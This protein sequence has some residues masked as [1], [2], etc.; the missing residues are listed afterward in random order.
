MTLP[1]VTRIVR[2]PSAWS[3]T[4]EK[5]KICKPQTSRS[6][7]AEAFALEAAR[8]AAA[9]AVAAQA[10]AEAEAR[11]TALAATAQAEDG[12]AVR[13]AA[14]E[15]EAAG[16]AAWA[17]REEP[18]NLF[19]KRVAAWANAFDPKYRTLAWVLGMHV[20][21]GT[22]MAWPSIETLMAD[23]EKALIKQ[24]G[25]GGVFKPSRWMVTDRLKGL[26][27]AGVTRTGKQGKKK[28]ETKG[29][30]AT[31][32]Y[33]AHRRFVDLHTVIQGGVAVHRDFY[34]PLASTDD[35]PGPE[36]T[37]PPAAPDPENPAPET[38][39]HR[40][41]RGLSG[42]RNVG[43]VAVQGPDSSPETEWSNYEH[44]TGG[45]T[46]H[47]EGRSNY[48]HGTSDGTSGGT[49]HIT[50]PSNSPTNG[51]KN[52]D[53][54]TPVITPADAGVGEH[55]G[56]QG[57]QGQD[58]DR[59]SEMD[60]RKA[61]W[62]ATGLIAKDFA[63][64]LDHRWRTLGA[65]PVDV[66]RLHQT[67][68]KWSYNHNCGLITLSEA[69]NHWLQARYNDKSIHNPAGLM[70]SEFG[71]WLVWAR[72]APP[73]RLRTFFKVVRDDK[74]IRG[75]KT[76]HALSAYLTYWDER[77]AIRPS[78]RWTA[79]KLVK[80]YAAEHDLE[81]P[82][83]VDPLDAALRKDWD[84][85]RGPD[86]DYARPLDN[87]KESWGVRNRDGT[88]HKID[89]PKEWNAVVTEVFE[90]RERLSELSEYLNS[91]ALDYDHAWADNPAEP[92][93]WDDIDPAERYSEE[94]TG[95]SE[96]GLLRRLGV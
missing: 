4:P 37:G 75:D 88:V 30:A 48:E 24:R 62:D 67:L 15:E 7:E 68:F 16:A 38:A 33:R 21:M 74:V 76:Y 87:G 77:E 57:P 71:Q 47:G 81:P 13:A 79:E 64:K 63:A 45:G 20:S 69:A 78:Y 65:L 17:Y 28:V 70:L 58:E 61:R 2:R 49:S 40:R 51:Q 90:R 82:P 32:V 25:G 41:N 91:D 3:T 11:A 10:E 9:K 85:H 18:P 94:N 95:F 96:E 59:L 22:G 44:G 72:H 55:P 73:M 31:W 8:A 83:E 89:D 60:L 53:H 6:P 54:K 36:D 56:H 12:A 1:A 80:A 42:R 14:A 93:D 27:A 66:G 23:W 35:P 26:E 43:P 50:V 29:Q 19:K 34:G 52:E 86:L 92:P 39:L 5:P 46:S 84:D